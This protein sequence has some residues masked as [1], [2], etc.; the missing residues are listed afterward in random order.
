[1]IDLRNKISHKKE[2][3]SFASSRPQINLHNS[4][5]GKSAIFKNGYDIDMCADI[6][7]VDESTGEV[8]VDWDCYWMPCNFNGKGKLVIK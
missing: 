6:L 7:G 1:M 8:Y 4:N 5:V 3:V 2:F